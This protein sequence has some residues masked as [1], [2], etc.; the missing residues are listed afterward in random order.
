[1]ECK[2]MNR[3]KDIKSADSVRV[4]VQK[5]A[6]LNLPQH[7]INQ[8]IRILRRYCWRQLISWFFHFGLVLATKSV[9]FWNRILTLEVTQS[10]LILESLEMAFRRFFPKSTR[11]SLKFPQWRL[12]CWISSQA[13]SWIGLSWGKELEGRNRKEAVG[14]LNIRSRSEIH[15]KPSC[16]FLP[17]I[18]WEKDQR[19]AALH[20]QRRSY[21]PLEEGDFALIKSS[22]SNGTNFSPM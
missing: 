6:D 1:M 11:K 13:K 18:S 10:H 14:L 17:K 15:R 8:G 12:A 21:V 4:R 19:F 20:S 22:C 5:L 7:D 16:Q 3:A 2:L 9:W